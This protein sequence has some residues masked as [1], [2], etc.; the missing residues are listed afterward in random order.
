MF[1]LKIYTTM[2]SIHNI[3][4]LTR[5]RLRIGISRRRE[6]EIIL[7]LPLYSSTFLEKQRVHIWEKYYATSRK[8]KLFLNPS[9]IQHLPTKDRK[10]QTSPNFWFL[11]KIPLIQANMKDL[12]KVQ[13]P[14][15]SQT[16]L[17]VL[18]VENTK[19]PMNI[20]KS[21]SNQKSI[22][23]FQMPSMK[24]S[25]TESSILKTMMSKLFTLCG[26]SPNWSDRKSNTET[27]KDIIYRLLLPLIKK[28]NFKRE[29]LLEKR[30]GKHMN[31]NWKK[32]AKHFFKKFH[33][34]KMSLR[35]K[36]WKS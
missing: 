22:Q 8:S 24:K 9:T 26:S 2:P 31:A 35:V 34:V 17:K 1:C 30:K 14:W 5:K 15:A 19:T 25:L 16:L 3:S 32:K 12:P 20:S 6:T 33:K 23:W 28:K 21:T 13:N 11:Q 4:K 10:F 7:K 18:L 29:N 27:S 36:E